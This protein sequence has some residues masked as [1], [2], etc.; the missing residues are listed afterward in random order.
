MS[1][2]TEQELDDYTNKYRLYET[3]VPNMESS[4]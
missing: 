3:A 1:D 2:D 4:N